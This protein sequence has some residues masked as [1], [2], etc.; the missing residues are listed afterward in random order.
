MEWQ[1]FLLE[2]GGRAEGGRI[3]RNERFGRVAPAATGTCLPTADDIPG[4]P[5]DLIL[6]QK[7]QDPAE[8][9]VCAPRSPQGYAVQVTLSAHRIRGLG[10]DLLTWDLTHATV[11]LLVNIDSG[12]TSFPHRGDNVE[13]GILRLRVDRWFDRL[14]DQ[15]GPC[16]DG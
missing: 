4:P 14:S 16:R 8:Q 10:R 3:F 12:R 7:P 5:G 1:E 13:A 15:L 6:L 11:R 2:M 9:C